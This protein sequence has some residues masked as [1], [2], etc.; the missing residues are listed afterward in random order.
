VSESDHKRARWSSHAA[1]SRWEKEFVKPS[2]DA[3]V[4]A[5][6][7]CG[8]DLQVSLVD[9]DDA[10]LARRR[11]RLQLSPAERLAGLTAVVT[12]IQRARAARGVT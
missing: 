5:A 10:E 3:V 8:L 2:W 7:A 6:R 11:E 12:F 4:D 1:I 9:R